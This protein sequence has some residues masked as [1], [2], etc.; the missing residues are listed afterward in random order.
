MFSD[1]EV[2]VVTQQAVRSSYL[3]YSTSRALVIDMLHGATGRV[4]KLQGKL[5]SRHIDT[6]FEDV[7]KEMVCMS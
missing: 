3:A 2:G 7:A 4:C 1:F 6:D 5:V